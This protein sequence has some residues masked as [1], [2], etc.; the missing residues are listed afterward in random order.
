MQAV[1][2]GIE[3]KIKARAIHLVENEHPE[4]EEAAAMTTKLQRQADHPEAYLS[5]Y[6]V[7]EKY[8]K[9]SFETFQG[10]EALK[11]LCMD[12][13]EES[14]LLILR[15]LCSGIGCRPRTGN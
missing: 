14:I 13:G 9:C 7:P 11:K 2:E 8:L 3:R 4:N 6:G 15:L 5:G 12:S 10:A 1:I